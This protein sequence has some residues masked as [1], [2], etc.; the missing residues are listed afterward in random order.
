[1]AG[2][3]NSYPAELIKREVIAKSRHALVVYGDM[4]FLRKKLYWPLSDQA[5]A[6]RR[7]NIPVGTIVALLESSGIKVF[8]IRTV[9][10]DPLISIQP[11]VASWET[12]SLT[13]VKDTVLGLEPLESFLT[14]GKWSIGFKDDKGQTHMEE[15]RPDPERSG[16]MQEQFDAILT[17]GPASS[18]EFSR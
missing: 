4:H 5:E 11:D 1:L 14:P 6:E 15:V 9:P 8:S 10:N 13:M 3:R 17:L 16:L 7:F 12:F 18:L 2:Q